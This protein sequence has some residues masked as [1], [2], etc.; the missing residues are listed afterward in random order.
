MNEKEKQEADKRSKM[1]RMKNYVQ[2]SGLG[3]QVVAII[4][5]GALFGKWIDGKM[6]NE[7]PAMTLVLTFLSVFLSMYY[8]YK[9]VNSDK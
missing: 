3:F 7:F 1:D 6:L 2:Y 4:V 9:K 8:L 5:L